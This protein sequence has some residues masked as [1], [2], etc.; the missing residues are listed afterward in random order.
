MIV[1]DASAILAFFVG[2]TGSAAVEAALDQEETACSAAN[3]SEVAQKMLAHGR[4]WPD[5]RVMI[6]ERGLIIEPITV[7]DAE[8][9]AEFW[10]TRR[11]LSLADRLCLALANRLGAEAWTT[12]RAWGA[13]PGVRQLR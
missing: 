9:A 6:L 8:W 5:A 3:W 7:E 1:L 13:E 2:E 11:D 10:I 4:N 12:D